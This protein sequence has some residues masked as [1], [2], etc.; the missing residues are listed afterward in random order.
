M[1][2]FL[3]TFNTEDEYQDFI[4][5]NECQYINVSHIIQTD[6][7]AYFKELYPQQLLPF[8]IEVLEHHTGAPL[9]KISYRDVTYSSYEAKYQIY[10]HT[11]QTYSDWKPFLHD[12]SLLYMENVATLSVGDK[13]RIIGNK[14]SDTFPGLSFFGFETQNGEDYK[15]TYPGELKIKISGNMLSFWT[16]DYVYATPESL[17]FR[18]NDWQSVGIGIQGLTVAGWGQYQD[19]LK[20]ASDLFLPTRGLTPNIFNGLFDRNS[21]LIAAPDILAKYLPDSACPNMFYDCKNLEDMPIIAAETVERCAFT[22]MFNNCTSL[23]NTTELHVKH[24]VANDSCNA[25]DRMFQSCYSLTA[26][27]QWDADIDLVIPNKYYSGNP[28]YVTNGQ[29]YNGIFYAMFRGCES[30]QTCNWHITFESAFD[31]NNDQK[32][33]RMFGSLYDEDLEERKICNALTTIPTIEIKNNTNYEQTLQVNH[34]IFY[35]GDGTKT[36]NLINS[37]TVLGIEGAIYVYDYNPP[38]GFD[39]SSGTFYLSSNSEYLPGGSLENDYPLNLYNWTKS[40]YVPS[41]P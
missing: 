23:V 27:P 10:D 12:G 38:T 26:A 18:I 30:L 14:S 5:S 1:N 36:Q 34:D 9:G 28:D 17:G 22:D 40:V 21:G 25:F 20:D 4:N 33:E 35:S 16:E 15:E 7:N 3:T 11:T 41:N 2:K 39:T 31:G 32:F 37:W 19:F 24:I 8:T 13:I 6:R 29:G